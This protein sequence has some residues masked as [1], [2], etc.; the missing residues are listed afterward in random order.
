MGSMNEIRFRDSEAKL[1]EE[2]MR[3]RKAYQL[4]GADRIRCD[5]CGMGHYVMPNI[6]ERTFE[7]EQCWAKRRFQELT[8]PQISPEVELKEKKVKDAE[9]KVITDNRIPFNLE[10][11]CRI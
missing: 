1:L 2:L 7:C 4:I 6:V 8:S 5:T 3:R 10:D 9:P 11:F